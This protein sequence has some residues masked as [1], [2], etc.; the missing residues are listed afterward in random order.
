M[1]NKDFNYKLFFDLSPDLL[2]IAGFDGYFKKV[3]TA[4]SEELQY[5]PEELYSRPINDFVYSEDKEITK[6][7]RADLTQSK[8]LFH[9]ENRYVRKNGEIIWLSW[10]SYPVQKD[11]VI[12]AIAKN[13]THKKRL[14]EDRNT[15][16]SNF[17]SMNREL[18]QLNYTTSHDLR[19]PV[20]SLL[21]LFSLI[22]G[23]KITDPETMEL[24]EYIQL[25]GNQLKVTLDKYVDS[26]TE[27][28]R[29]GVLLEELNLEE[30][31]QN[32]RQSIHP[33][34]QKTGVQWIIDFSEAPKV[35]FNKSYMESIFL[36]LIT[37]SIKYSKNN[38]APEI[39]IYSKKL[40]GVVQLVFMDNGIGFDMEMVKNRIFKLNQKFHNYADSKGIGLFLVHNHITSLGGQIELESKVGDGAK[41]TLSILDN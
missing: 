12:F 39:S 19:A 36:N 2:C 17:S 32:V 24:M 14:E 23:S 9:F 27:K 41:F 21:S 25:A 22:D 28:H 34:I 26:L 3:N 8:A 29:D 6:K 10:T 18:K 7:V 4:V 20:N 31:L 1:T 30:C 33:L 13:I 35:K 38:E 40:K 37:N 11:R 16:L 5:T 15:M